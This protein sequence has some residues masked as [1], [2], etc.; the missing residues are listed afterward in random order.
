MP[1]LAPLSFAQQRLWLLDQLTPRQSRY[2]VTRTFELTGPLDH[3]ALERSVRLVAERHAVLRSRIVLC[4]GEPAAVLEPA[5]AVALERI[6]LGTQTEPTALLRAAASRHCDLAAGP[7]LRT[8]VIEVGAGRHLFQYTVHH[9]VFDALSRVIFEEELAAAYAAFVAGRPLALPALSMRYSDHA[10]RERATVTG[11]G[12]ASQEAYWMARLAGAACM[13]W[14]ADRATLPEP[15]TAAQQPIAIAAPVRD[16]LLG[17]AAA[18]R[19]SLFAVMLAAYQY[20]L[21]QMGRTDDVLVGI[22]VGG[23]PELELETLIGFFANTVVL[24]ADLTG[25][26]SLR[27]LIRQV[28]EHVLDALDNQEVPFDRIVD[29]LGVD[30][31]SRR[32]PLFQHWFGF[33]DGELADQS[34]RVPGIACRV[35]AQRVLTTRFDT[36]L[37]MTMRGGDLAGVLTYSTELFDSLTMRRFAE[38][39]RRILATGSADP[40]APL[41]SID[42]LS[43]QEQRELMSQAAGSC[44]GVAMPAGSPERSLWEWFAEQ[45]R[46]SPDTTAVADAASELTYGELHRAACQLAGRLRGAGIGPGNVVAIYLPRCADAVV[47][48][49]ATVRTGAA[50]LPMGLEVPAERMDYMLADSGAAALL[51]H[52]ALLPA[53]TAPTVPTVLAVDAVDGGPAPGPA[54][55]EPGAGPAGERLLYLIYTSGSTGRP[56][57]VAVSHRQFAGLVRWH[58]ATYQ[59]KAGDRI[60]QLANLSFDAAAWDLWS[61]LLAG[62]CLRIC[63]DELVRD[64]AAL[65]DWLSGHGIN[66]VFAPTP[67]AEQLIR[68]RLGQVTSLRQL[69][70][71]GDVFRPRADDDAGVPVINHYGPTENAVV[72]T[73]T[74]PLAAPWANNSIGRPISGVRTYLTDRHIRLVPYGV[75]GELCLGGD[76]VSWGYW[77]RPGLTAERFVPDPF[78]AKPGARLYRTGDLARWRPDGALQYLG[79]ID[80]QIEVNGHRIEPAEVEAELLVHGAVRAAAVAAK[81]SPAGGQLLVGYVVPDGAMPAADELRRHL[82]RQLPRYMIPRAFVSLAE[83]PVTTSG[84]LDRGRLPRLEQVPGDGTAPRTMAEKRMASL[85]ADLLGVTAVGAHDDFFALG[86]NSFSAARLLNRIRATFGIDFSLR[87]I[88]DNAS[89]AELS[90]AVAAQMRTEIEAMSPDQIA[91]ALAENGAV[92]DM[93]TSTAKNKP[94]LMDFA[95]LPSATL[96]DYVKEVTNRHSVLNNVLN[97]SRPGTQEAI[98]TLIATTNEFDSDETG[99]GDSY[100]RAQENATVRWTGA[101]QLLRLCIPRAPARSAVVLDVLG[102]DGTLARAVKVKS[103]APR[104]SVLTGDISGHMVERALGLGLPAIRQAAQFLFLRDNSVDAVLLAYGTHHITPGDRLTVVREAFRVVRPGGRVVVHDFD[105]ASPMVHFFERVVHANS[106]AGHD[107]T[108]FSRESLHRIFE[109]ASVTAELAYIYDPYLMCGTTEEDAQVQMCQYI[110][111][112]YGL[113]HVLGSRDDIDR[114]WQTLVEEFDHTGYTAQLYG[115]RDYPRHPVIYREDGSFVAEVPRVAI[116]AS[117]EK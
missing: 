86:G 48:I 66:S 53:I 97:F 73:A 75:V 38:R 101:Q 87:G 19:T 67:L 68:E 61:A 12:L 50:Y 36:E 80:E 29:A 37:E 96:R 117:A 6:E 114:F 62:A 8:A 11:G 84:K 35:L 100:R 21:G 109:E 28:R 30:R 60:A 106:K 82:A 56:K 52:Q 18:E 104:L 111:N 43:A 46:H 71:G 110:K 23:R 64:P 9:I 91:A 14:P 2:L 76:G 32:N 15:F 24:R 107:Y 81:T 89:L 22:P 102:G 7:P 90:S 34:L 5:D 31:D 45:A 63:P 41:S 116:V 16:R 93:L 17:L 27:H 13:D 3:D 58:L 74:V 1:D 98:E 33:A 77:R 108:H 85:W 10:T 54:Q 55:G 112:M 51:T 40:D 44:R 113:T 69:L 39:Y 65:V 105:N 57:G 78:G 4:D 70:T 20:L 79:R 25:T 92:A 42:L 103:A 95:Y 99:R 59:P 88:F 94:A 72:A 47:A 115:D 83:L 26:P 49:L